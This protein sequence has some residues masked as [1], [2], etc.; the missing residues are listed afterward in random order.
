MTEQYVLFIALSEPISSNE[1][2]RQVEPYIHETGKFKIEEDQ[3]ERIVTEGLVDVVHKVRLR[4][5]LLEVNR[6]PELCANALIKPNET[7]ARKLNELS[8]AILKPGDFVFMTSDEGVIDP[9]EGSPER[10]YAGMIQFL[11]E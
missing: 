10:R 5:G 9:N 2:W 4:N 6:E 7:T 11:E 3:E 1:F 8:H